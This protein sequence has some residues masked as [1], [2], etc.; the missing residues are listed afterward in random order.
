MEFYDHLYL[1]LY[2]VNSYDRLYLYLWGME[3][4]S[5]IYSY[6]YKLKFYDHLHLY[7]YK[8][9]LY[10]H[11]RWH[12]YGKYSCDVSTKIYLRLHLNKYNLKHPSCGYHHIHHY[13]NMWSTATSLLH[14]IWF[15]I[16]IIVIPRTSEDKS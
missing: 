16:T 12:L 2:K 4:Y 3:F 11:L 13:N 8:V 9:I 7:L 10:S 5:H 14:I 15:V 6:L 1:H